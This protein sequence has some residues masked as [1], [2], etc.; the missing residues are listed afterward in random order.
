MSQ[1]RVSIIMAAF[2][3]GSNVILDQAIHSVL[4]QSLDD[5]EFLICDDA[6]TDGTYERLLFWQSQDPRIRVFRNDRN[7]KSA[8]ARNRCLKEAQGKYIAIMDADDA[9]TPNRLQTQV[10]FLESHLPFSFV[11][12]LGERFYT[13]P[14]DRDHP[15]WFCPAP[16]PKDFL[17]T[18]PFVHASLMFRREALLSVN[19]YCEDPRAERSEDYDMLLR[20]YAAGFYGANIRDAVYY[21]RENADTFQRRKYCYRFKETYVKMTGFSRLGLMPGG[22]AYAMKPLIVGLFP[23]GLLEKMKRLYYTRK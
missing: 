21:I 16:Q 20:L 22:F 23:N 4:H 17:M 19:G 5:F 18:L 7:R 10:A 8:A 15:Y 9:C 1:P 2:N 11:G 13:S 14:G 6:S 3:V 12:L